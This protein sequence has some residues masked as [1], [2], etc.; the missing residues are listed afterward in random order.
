MRRASNDVEALDVARQPDGKVVAV[1][2]RLQ[3]AGPGANLVVFRLEPDG[4][5]DTGFGY[6][7]NPRP[8][9]WKSYGRTHR[10]TAI[11]LE[12]DGRIVVAGARVRET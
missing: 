8:A 5:L 11:S 9:R 4:S 1:G 2:R 7:G 12:P 10:G 3:G 6:G